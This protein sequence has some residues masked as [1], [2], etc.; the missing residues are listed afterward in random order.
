MNE[1]TING[2]GTPL[3]SFTSSY[4]GTTYYGWAFSA[5]VNGQS[6]IVIVWIDS[7]EESDAAADAQETLENDPNE[8]Q[9]ISVNDPPPNQDGNPPNQDDGLHDDDGGGNQ[10]ADGY[11]DGTSDSA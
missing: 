5:T 1:V 7:N 6:G 9:P 3:G 10:Y 4:D 8:L 11:G 2:P